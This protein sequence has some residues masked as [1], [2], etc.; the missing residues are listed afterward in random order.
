MLGVEEALELSGSRF[1][2]VDAY[3]L[4]VGLMMTESKECSQNHLEVQLQ[5]HKGSALLALW[6]IDVGCCHV[7]EILMKLNNAIVFQSKCNGM[8][9]ASGMWHSANTDESSQQT[10]L[11]SFLLLRP[12]ESEQRQWMPFQLF[13]SLSQ[14]STATNVDLANDNSSPET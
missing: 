2:D 12:L 10:S 9:F 11:I 7:N 6:G 14:N 1:E 13:R 8:I 3:T 4:L 5:R